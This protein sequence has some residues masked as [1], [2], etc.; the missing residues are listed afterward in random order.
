MSLPDPTLAIRAFEV[1]TELRSAAD[2]GELD[3]IVRP[4]LA[5]MGLAHFASARFYQFDGSEAPAFLHGRLPGEWVRRYANRR[6]SGQSP[7]ARQM[8]STNAA[9]SWSSVLARNRGD[10]MGLRIWNEARDFGLCD[11]LYIP[12]RGADS[13]YTAVVLAGRRPA[14]NDPFIRIAAELVGGHYG[15]EGRRLRTTDEAA[16]ANLTLRQR[17]CLLWV[18][19]GKSSSVIADI[20]GISAGTVD[21]HIRG[22]CNNL[23]VRTR[24]QAV[25]QATRLGLLNV[26]SV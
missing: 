6:Y 7:I 4:V 5:E 8:L 17:E 3:K 12:L 15:L 19:E 1:V 2:I 18:R 9:Y 20:L 24:V 22:A 26:A 21:E 16:P 10:N 14:F 11:G 25:I 13:S 23:G